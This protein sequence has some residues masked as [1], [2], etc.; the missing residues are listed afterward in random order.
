MA[1]A[2]HLL[3]RC[4]DFFFFFWYPFVFPSAKFQF[5]LALLDMGFM[6]Q[7]VSV[8]IPKCFQCIDNIIFVGKFYKTSGILH[9]LQEGGC[10]CHLQIL[11]LVWWFSKR[12]LEIREWWLAEISQFIYIFIIIQ[13][14]G[15][16][17][18]ILYFSFF[19]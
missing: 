1:L 7:V 14:S 6:N 4:T 3:W 17:Q 8:E 18:C 15:K 2:L 12:S 11:P 16:Y 9:F 10:R 19:F 13:V 5:V